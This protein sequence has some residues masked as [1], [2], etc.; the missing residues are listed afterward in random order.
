MKKV[1]FK[2]TILAFGNNTGIEIPLTVIEALG[3]SKKPA[4]MVSVGAY[5]YSSTVAVMQKKFLVPLSKEHREKSGLKAGDRVD[6]TLE[7]ILGFREII[8]PQILIDFLNKHQLYTQF[9][10]K[11]YSYRKEVV[12]QVLDAKKTETLVKRLEHIKTNLNQK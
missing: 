9:V 10:Q 3:Q 12:R 1:S 8:L 4:V 2:T 6:V 5:Q 7:L 11:S